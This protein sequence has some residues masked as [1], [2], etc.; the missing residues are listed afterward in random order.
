MPDRS[1][2]QSYLYFMLGDKNAIHPTTITW[3]TR[4]TEKNIYFLPHI[5]LLL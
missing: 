4:M 2:Q 5:D 3:D 1:K